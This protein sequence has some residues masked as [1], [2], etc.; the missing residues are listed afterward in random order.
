MEFFRDLDVSIRETDAN[1]GSWAE[2]LAIYDY[3][4]SLYKPNRNFKFLVWNTAKLKKN[5]HHFMIGNAETYGKRVVF[6][7]EDTEKGPLEAMDRPSLS[8]Q[9]HQD[10]ISKVRHR[11]GKE[12]FEGLATAELMLGMP[13]QS[14]GTFKENFKRF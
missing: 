5:A 11:I 3:A 13:E 9:Q 1:F 14:I 4:K 12:R 6:S 7:F 10:M 2:D 8:W